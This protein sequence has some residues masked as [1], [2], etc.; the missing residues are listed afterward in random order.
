MFINYDT[1][2][3]RDDSGNCCGDEG[4]DEFGF[5]E[6]GTSGASL[7]LNKNLI[8]SAVD[9]STNPNIWSCP[10]N[11]CWVPASGEAKFQIILVNE[12]GENAYDV[13]SNNQKWVEC[14]GP[15]AGTQDISINT[16]EVAEANRFYCYK[17]G[18]RWSWA[19]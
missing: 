13:V 18:N 17:K 1:Q 8:G 16:I 4:I 9:I 6:E 3:K 14:K 7:C 19:E 15:S 5:I 11:W 2:K 12:P 10:G